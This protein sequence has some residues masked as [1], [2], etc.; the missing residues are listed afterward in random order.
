MG[1]EQFEELT[2][3]HSK[4]AAHRFATEAAPA[5]QSFAESS[6]AGFVSGI[7]AARERIVARDDDERTAFLRRRGFSK[8][9]TAKV[10]EAVLTEEGQP[11]S[12]VFDFVQG[13]TAVARAETRQDVRLEAEM[14]AKRLLDQVSA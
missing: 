9:D 13:I 8:G 6:A 2:I 12:S 4:R 3:R 1:V 10:I 14:K 11:P 5:L 7:R